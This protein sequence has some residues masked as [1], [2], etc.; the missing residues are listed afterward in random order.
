MTGPSLFH[1]FL[2]YCHLDHAD[3]HVAEALSIC[4]LRARYH[5]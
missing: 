1:E 4:S 5:N 3:E 2:D